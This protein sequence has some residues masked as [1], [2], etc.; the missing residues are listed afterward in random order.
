MNNNNYNDQYEYHYSYTNSQRPGPG[1]NTPP[2][3]QPP[4]KGNDIGSW[5]FNVVM[6]FVFPPIGLVLTIVQAMGSNLFARLI[7]SLFRRIRYGRSAPGSYARHTASSRTANAQTGARPQAEQA[8]QAKT[9]QAKAAQ[10]EPAAK[11]EPK[12]ERGF[13]RVDAGS[14]A[15]NVFGW[16]LLAFGVIAALG[17]GGAVWTLITGLCIALGGG[18]MLLR[19]LTSRRKAKAFARCITVSGTEGLVDIPKLAATLGMKSSELEKQ[20]TEMIDRGY[21]GPKAYI[22]HQRALLVITPE[23]MRDVYRREDEAKK[24]AAER[25]QEAQ[26]SEYDRIIAAIA[27]ADED[28]D[29]EAMSEKIRRMQS[30]TAA[31][32]QEVEEHPEKKSQI[33]R[34]MNYYLPTT[35]KLLNAYARIEEQGVTGEN[36]AKAKADIEGIAD[37]LVDGY[38]KQLDTLYRAEAVDI[39]SD[40]RVIEKMMNADGLTGGASPFRT[41]AGEG[42]TMG[43]H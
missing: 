43:G 1:P 12:A 18:A 36:M 6:L 40:V 9:A 16:I 30:I 11:S 20:L 35:L 8:A 26:Q 17:S 4:R 39:A 29:D 31:I 32:F 10:A 27:Q 28:I 41:T 42:Q 15:L 37:T 2:D 33:T 13:D 25:E 14:G 3:P 22:D 21:Y 19:S 24:T 23:D 34:F 7:S 5:I 38:E